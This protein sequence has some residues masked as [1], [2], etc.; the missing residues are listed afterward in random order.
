MPAH[1]YEHPGWVPMDEVFLIFEREDFEKIHKQEF[2]E[3]TGSYD[4]VLSASRLVL[5][6][7]PGSDRE[8]IIIDDKGASKISSFAYVH[9]A[10]RDSEGREWGKTREDSW[11]CLS[12]PDN[13]NIPAFYPAPDA[14]KWSPGRNNDWIT[15]WLPTDPPANKANILK[16]VS[17]AVVPVLS[18]AVLVWAIQKQRKAR[19]KDNG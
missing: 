10:Y 4:A 18:V 13:S 3:Y 12:D 5:W 7:W 14:K 15:I 8:K 9:Y 1:N 19:R 6:Q 11:I 16:T 17:L 2:Y